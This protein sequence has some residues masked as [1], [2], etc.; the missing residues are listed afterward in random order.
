MCGPVN[1]IRR[2]GV[3]RVPRSFEPL[4]GGV[5]I[6]NEE[7]IIKEDLALIEPKEMR[8]FFFWDNSRN[9]DEGSDYFGNTVY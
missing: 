9:S 1:F 4:G 3:S 7:R 6:P 2:M 5:V 8:N